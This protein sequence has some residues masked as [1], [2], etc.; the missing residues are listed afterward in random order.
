[1]AS[2]I[3]E[4]IIY[5]QSQDG[6]IRRLAVSALGKIADKQGAKPLLELLLLEEKPQVRQYIVKALGKIGDASAKSMLEAIAQ[7]DREKEYTREAARNA[8]KRLSSEEKKQTSPVGIDRPYAAAQSEDPVAAFLSH[9][10]P[11]PLLG[12]WHVGWALSFHSQF[13]GADWNRS[14][15][16]ELAYR[17]K[18]HCDLTAL[19]ELVEQAAALIADHLEL[20]EVD[21]IVPVPPS[22]QRSIDPVSSFAKAL[23]QQLNLAF[24]ACSD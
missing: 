22:I 9:S 3:S 11:R 2:A 4:L 20:A 21:A 12:P 5:L 13:A 7:D 14:K 10:H 16:G 17:L 15:T 23:A 24:F 6:N 19:P 1:M 18:Y 8:I